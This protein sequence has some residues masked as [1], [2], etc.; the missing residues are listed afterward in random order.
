MMIELMEL[1]KS[2][3]APERIL[4]LAREFGAVQRLR[5]IHPADLCNALVGCSMGDEERSIAA[6]RRLYGQIAGYAPEESSFYDR[7]NAG[8]A[9]LMKTLYQQALA[10]ATNEQRAAVG[11]V[12][13]DLGLKDILAI[14][15]SQVMLPATAYNVL[16]STSK[17]HGGFKVT[18]TLSVAY[19]ALRRVNITNARTHDRKALKLD[20]WLTDQLLLLDRGYW[21]HWLLAE[22]ARR[23]GFFLT[24]LK[25]TSIPTIEKIRFGLG[26]RHVGKPLVDDLPYRGDCDL[27]ARFSIRGGRPQTF[28]VVGVSVLKKN[29]DGTSEY[30]DIWLVTNLPPEVISAEQ[31]AT[32]YRLRWDVEIL[33]KILKT[34]ARMDQLRSASEDVINAFLYAALLGLI[35]AQRICAEMR[36]QRPDI[37]PSLYR[38]TALVLGYVPKIVGA[39]TTREARKVLACLEQALWREGVNPNPGRPYKASQYAHEFL[40][41]S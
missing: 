1:F 16:P 19:Q 7:F 39:S 27:D 8:L 28:R 11:A 32:L 36:R 33:F 17:D 3:F 30:V 34:V 18:A 29:E 2:T 6:A 23:K 37:E 40:G 22:I 25:I 41:G 15:G 24:P 38:V 10:A 12:L 13:K 31:L 14:D 4:E 35:L 5:N 20:R 9:K 26:Q 21:D